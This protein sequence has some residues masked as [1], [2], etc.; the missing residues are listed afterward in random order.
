MKINKIHV[1]DDI[2]NLKKQEEIKN[3]LLGN[4]FNWHYI[5]D[6]SHNDGVQKRPAF[7]HYFVLDEEVNSDFNYLTNDIIVN[8]CKT[9]DI[10]C[11]K[12]IESR[13]FLQLPLHDNITKGDLV[14][15]P[16]IDRETEHTVI[17][18][19]V[20]TADGDTIIYD[21]DK[22]HKITPKQGRVVIFN[23]SLKHTATQPIDGSRCII[24]INIC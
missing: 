18:Y 23:G 3:N 5:N 12:V 2:I 7:S 20:Q 19:Y 11:N 15:T 4:D 1:V 16:H 17:L 22:E 10:D 6:I 9:V 8:S 13:T 24:N 21:N 14:D